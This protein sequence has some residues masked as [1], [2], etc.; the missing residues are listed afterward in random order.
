MQK[1]N[2]GFRVK[3]ADIAN[4]TTISN[5]FNRHS[6]RC[7]QSTGQGTRIEG[8]NDV[9][10]LRFQLR[11]DSFGTSFIKTSLQGNI[12]NYSAGLRSEEHTSKL[13]SR[14]HLVCRLLLEKK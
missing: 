10:S 1:R 12:T 14:P 8:M 4:H 3:V 2:P 5:H 11:L 13:Q 6:F 9:I 7:S